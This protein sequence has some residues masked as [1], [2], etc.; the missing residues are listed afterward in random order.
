MAAPRRASP[1]SS[2]K[3]NGTPDFDFNGRAF[4]LVNSHGF[5]LRVDSLKLLTAPSGKW[6]VLV[7]VSE[8]STG[9]FFQI[10]VDSFAR[11]L[12]FLPDGTPDSAFAQ[13]AMGGASVSAQLNTGALLGTASGPS[14]CSLARFLVDGEPRVDAVMIE[15]YHPVL[16]HYFMTLDTFEAAGLDANGFGWTRTGRTFGAW[17]PQD[18]PD[19]TPVCRFYGD[20][21]IGPNSHFY[22][23]EGFEC[24]GLIALDA[25]TPAGQPA[26]H[27]EGK[28]FRAALPQA[29]GTC[30]GN[31]TGVYRAFNGPVDNAHGPN[32]RYTTDPGLYA[33]MLAAGWLA[34]G[35]HFCVPPLGPR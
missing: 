6:T 5:Q 7:Q 23:P 4:S 21:V 32:H 27:L 22:T 33:Q 10:T 12:R 16:R 18:V 25:R 15:Y 30:A 13:A 29:D 24:D 35:I 26:W 20:P 9:G 19:T 11:A 14:G 2:Y 34:E 1:C 8:I 31:L 17:Q 28:P 3:P